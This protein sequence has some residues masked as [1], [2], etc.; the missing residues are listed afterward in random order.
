MQSVL[1]VII[2]QFWRGVF[3]TVQF[4]KEDATCSKC[5]INVWCNLATPF[6]IPCALSLSI[7]KIIW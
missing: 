3:I 5:A 1:Y 2:V 6:L 7:D 4:Q